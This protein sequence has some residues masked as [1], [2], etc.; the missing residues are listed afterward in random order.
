MAYL[1]SWRIR[2]ALVIIDLQNSFISPRGS[3]DKLGYDISKYQRIVPVIQKTYKKAKSLK[4]SVFFSKAIR[5]KS[6]VDMLD[7]LHKILPR[8]RRERIEKLPICVRNTWDSE[9]IDDL[10]PRSDDLIVEKRRDSIFQ[11]TEFELWLKSLRVDTLIFT[12]VDTSICVESSLRDAFNKGWDVILLADAT[13]SLDDRFYETTL[14][15]VKENFG[16]V[17]KSGEF[18]SNLERIGANYFL[19]KTD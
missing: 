1:T 11:D 17:I 4:I 14:A 8:K 9:I 19:L 10:K 5:E 3:F 7:R 15:E 18:F 12:G 16:L 6:G 2:P 13:A